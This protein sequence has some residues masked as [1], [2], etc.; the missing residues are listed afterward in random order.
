MCNQGQGYESQSIVTINLFNSVLSIFNAIYTT[1]KLYDL[2]ICFFFGTKLRT[3][4]L[5]IEVAFIHEQN[6]H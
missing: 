6:I 4:I 2:Y 1:V 5:K 3:F